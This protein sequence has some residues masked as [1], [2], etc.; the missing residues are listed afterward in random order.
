MFVMYYISFY[1]NW[2]P[3]W[4]STGNILEGKWCWNFCLERCGREFASDPLL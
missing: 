4:R 3:A 2:C 1:R